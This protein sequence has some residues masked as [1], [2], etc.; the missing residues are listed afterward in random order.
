MADND[1]TTPTPEPLNPDPIIQYL[2]LYLE[3][4]VADIKSINDN[5]SGINNTLKEVH[6]I[7]EEAHEKATEALK[8]AN[9]AQTTT[10]TAI[11]TINES[12]LKMINIE[13]RLKTLES[14]NEEFTL[15]SDKSE[16]EKCRSHLP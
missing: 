14:S 16:N 6:K 15:Q 13:R 5:I 11:K 8:T 9:E 7:A 3:P 12:E 10:N 2:K 1:N 4:I